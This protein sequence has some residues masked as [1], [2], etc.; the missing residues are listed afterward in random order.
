MGCLFELFFEI[1]VEVFF[2]LIVSCYI[3]L[4]TL[5]VPDKM[6]TDRTKRIIKNIAT[7]VA[8]VLGVILVVGL[9]FLLQ[10]DPFI[11]NIGKFMTYIPL[12]IIALQVTLGILTK[13]I[14]HFKSK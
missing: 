7:T 9:I 12:G 10:D 6:I 8:A 4:M 1:F 11:K 13:M 5:I 3:K 14:S 2:E